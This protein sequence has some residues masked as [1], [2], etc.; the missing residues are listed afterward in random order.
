M[1]ARGAEREAF[2]FDE[3][4]EP[5]SPVALPRDRLRQILSATG[6]DLYLRGD[7]LARD[8]LGEER[9]ADSRGVAQPLERA[10]HV[11]AAAVEDREL[12][13]E[14]DGE[15]DAAREALLDLVEVEVLVGVGVHGL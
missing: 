5:P 11:E 14:P 3:R 15:I 7:Q 10:D 13:L 8:S 2:A 4:E 1:R 12:L 9:V 6:D